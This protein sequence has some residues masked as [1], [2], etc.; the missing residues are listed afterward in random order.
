MRKAAEASWPRSDHR[1]C[2]SKAGTW[3]AIATDVLFYRGRIA[4][5][6]LR[7]ASKP[8]TRMEPAARSPRPSRPRWRLATIL[9]K[10]SHEPKRYITA[11]DSEQSGP[12]IRIRAAGSSRAILIQAFESAVVRLLLGLLRQDERCLAGPQKFQLLSNLQLLL[13]GAAFQLL[14]ALAPIIVLA[15]E[16]G[17]L[18]FQLAN[19]GPAFSSEPEGLGDRAIP[20]SHR[21]RSMRK[22][23]QRGRG[24]LSYSFSAV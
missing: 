1:R 14:D 24:E 9:R 7:R 17:V 13:G 5:S 2:W 12:G 3:Q 18:F 4:R 20:P 22:R 10:Q 19:L 21:R 23:S 8:A 15:L 6:S 11:G 16:I